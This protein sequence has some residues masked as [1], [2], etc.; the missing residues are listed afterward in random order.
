MVIKHLLGAA[1]FAGAVSIAT[2]PV[3]AQNHPVCSQGSA[4]G[5][6]VS[7]RCEFDSFRQ[8]RASTSGV[9]GTCIRNPSYARGQMMPWARR[10]R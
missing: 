10:Y 8:C 9:G 3:Q 5:A 6:G 7:L 1:L 4:M 2:L